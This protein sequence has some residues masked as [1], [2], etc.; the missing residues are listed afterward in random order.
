MTELPAV[1]AAGLPSVR[2]WGMQGSSMCWKGFRGPTGATLRVLQKRCN[3]KFERKPMPQVQHVG[4]AP[5]TCRALCSPLLPCSR[6]AV[7]G[8]QLQPQARRRGLNPASVTWALDG[9][10][11]TTPALIPQDH[12]SCIRLASPRKEAGTATGPPSGP[13]MPATCKGACTR[14]PQIALDHSCL[15]CS[16]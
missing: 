14:H 9:P 3:G 6:Q 11:K 16:I 1:A 8:S 13:L 12:S 2:G 7:H 15:V 10:L 5:G 4:Q